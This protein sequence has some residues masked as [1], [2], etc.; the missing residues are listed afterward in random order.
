MAYL[1]IISFVFSIFKWILLL[2]LLYVL[3]IVYWYIYCPYRKRQY[4][5]K[6]SNVKM[7]DRFYPMLGDV[8]LWKENFKNGYGSYHHYIQEAADDPNID[9]RFTQIGER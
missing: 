2:L 7:T 1:D 9:F 6:Y 8:A 3:N 5:K 4:F